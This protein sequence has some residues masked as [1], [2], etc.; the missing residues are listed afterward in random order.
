MNQSAPDC[1]WP[2]DLAG[3]RRDESCTTISASDVTDTLHLANPDERP[4][5][6][7]LLQLC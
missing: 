1:A 5:E 6:P 2:F 4:S 7:R 3:V